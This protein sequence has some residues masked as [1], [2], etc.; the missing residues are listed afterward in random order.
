[1]CWLLIIVQIIAPSEFEVRSSLQIIAGVL[2][3][4]FR[5]SVLEGHVKDKYSYYTEFTSWF[6]K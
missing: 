6:Q 4:A 2:T 1:M 5:R 3:K